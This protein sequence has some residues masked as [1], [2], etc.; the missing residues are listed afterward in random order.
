MLKII[1]EVNFHLFHLS[2]LKLDR[3]EKYF[4]LLSYCK[5]I[6]EDNTYVDSWYQWELLF[7]KT[8]KFQFSLLVIT[9][10]QIIIF[11][12]IIINKPLRKKD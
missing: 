6:T 10:Y 8:N 7:I 2:T 5:Q 11:N 12:K 3:T 4:S 9:D 1:K